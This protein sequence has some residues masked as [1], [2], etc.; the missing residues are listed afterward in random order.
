MNTYKLNP[1]TGNVDLFGDSAYDAAIKE[2]NDSRYCKRVGMDNFMP[3]DLLVYYGYLSSFNHPTNAWTNEK[4]AQDFSRYNILVLGE[5]YAPTHTDYA[6]TLIILARIKALKP[7]IKI[8]CYVD[9]TKS[10]AV[11]EAEIDDISA[12]SDIDGV[13]IDRAGYD[14]GQTRTQMNAKVDYVHASNASIC[15][16][17][18]FFIDHVLG[19]DNDPAYPNSTYNTGLVHSTLVED[20][21]YLMESFVVNTA[22][23]TGNNGYIS[24]D[25][26]IIRGI[27][28]IEKRKEYK[29]KI[30]SLSVINNGNVNANTLF[31]F[32]FLS[33]LIFSLD[34]Q[35]SSDIGFGASS[36]IVDFID[37]KFSSNLGLLYELNPS[38]TVDVL[39]ATM[40]HRYSGKAH[41]SCD[42]SLTD[43]I[44][45]I[46]MGTYIDSAML[47]GTMPSLDVSGT[48]SLTLSV[49]ANNTAA[50]AGGLVA[51]NLYRTNGDPDTI[52]IVH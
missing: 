32:H 44:I 46:D 45:T 35:G 18:A 7:S 48:A 33:S 52:C 30:A 24:Q 47:R 38:V 51:G 13:I 39:T 15:L 28:A 17:N 37:R 10:Q 21:W 5:I 11:F 22:A 26:W 42:Y 43:P 49:Y 29:I 34:A 14:F 19:I 3:D 25:D 12:I 8:F 2:E 36:A 40:Y 9:G 4:V 23:Y 1:Y 50:I 27:A 20:D 6:N 31:H 16:M 41:L